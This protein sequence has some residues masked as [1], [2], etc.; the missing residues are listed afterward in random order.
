MPES[1]VTFTALL[2]AS[3]AASAQEAERRVDTMDIRRGDAVTR[4]DAIAEGVLRVRVS[5]PDGFDE[6][7]SW[8]VAPSIRAGRA[9][10]ELTP[11]GLRTSSLAVAVDAAGQVTIRDAG[12]RVIIADAAPVKLQGRGFT[13][14]KR[15]EG[16]ERFYGLGDK[17]GGLDRRG[18]DF[19]DWNTDV[20]R[21]TSS[22][23]P[24]YKAIP[25]LISSGGA[26]G[27]YGLFLDNT[28]RVRFDIGKTDPEQLL[29]G[30]PDGPI[31]YYVIAGPTVADV[32]R[33]YAEL[34]GKAPLAPLWALG[35]QQSRYSYMTRAE[36]EQV[37]ERL[38]TER[39]PTDVIWLDI[40][41][42]DRNRPF[43]VNRTAF[44]DF[45][46]M[47]RGLKRRG[48]KTVTITDL[49][50]ARAED[51]YAPYRSGS[52]GDHFVRDAAGQV[53]VGPVWP[54]PSVFP[55]F[56]L[57]KS[58]AWWGTL[59]R[60]FV[61]AGVAG[62][63]NDMNEPAL[64][65]PSKTMSP[66]ARH[67]ITGDGFADRVAT[68]AEIHNVYGMLN[69]RAT[70]E[71]LLKLRPDERPFVMTRATYAGGQRYAVTWTGDNSSTWDHLKMSVHQLINL[72]LSGFS[73]SAA[74]IG[75]FTGGASPEL[76]TRWYQIGAWTPVF[77]NHAAN[78]AP[79]AEPWVDGP[80]HLALRRAAIVE[81][82]RLMPYIYALAERH[83]RTGDPIM[84]PVFYDHA[85]L[86]RAGCDQSMAFT[87]GRDLLVA[88]APTP[89][90]PAAY[91]VCLPES[92]WYDYWTG[93]RVVEKPRPPAN[94]ASLF[95]Q[96]DDIRTVET[97]TLARLP[98]FVR[99]GAIIPK[100]PAVM[101]TGERP[102]GPLELHVYPGADCR[103]T[104]YAD[105]G[106]TLAHTRGSFLRQAVRCEQTADG[107]AVTID[108]AEGSFRPWWREVEVVVHGW[109]PGDVQVKR[110]RATIPAVTDA[111]AQTA[112][113]RVPYRPGAMTLR[114]NTR[115]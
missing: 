7:A 84:R 16:G 39:I 35:Y 45:A 103:G 80:E 27:A 113:V 114:F 34:T 101:N 14:S 31:D 109:M 104:L 5:R 3:G 19:V 33:R 58:R 89:E 75:G 61:D 42:Q 28:W 70:Y 60:E 82:Y 46:G 36:T 54:G 38:R 87:L 2:L 99:P 64:F 81:R 85:A 94:P 107:V 110:A 76:L 68:H 10:V 23:D 32:T 52:A 11:D 63:W 72:G 9:K 24:L 18:G 78:N 4:V 44:P 57:P 111:R 65:V 15:I 17:T 105:D 102:E 83:A 41:F 97:P 8:A 92:G 56:T 100:Q 40:D 71:G 77:R 22:S 25:F 95:P 47:V 12:G 48:L 115:R 62:F 108:R 90:S 51:G 93:A 69:T 106:A 43:T 59:Y 13:L 37:A 20:G 66:D 29:M 1:A 53:V 6:D 73:Y 86:T 50:I 98:V 91:D 74:D 30:A 21:F 96:P 49:H 112:S 55:E 79:R 67:R 88:P 26:G